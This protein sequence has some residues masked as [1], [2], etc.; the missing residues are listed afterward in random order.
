MQLPTNSANA[1]HMCT[2]ISLTAVKHAGSF[3]MHFRF[4]TFNVYS[5]YCTNHVWSSQPKLWHFFFEST[6]KAGGE[7]ARK[8]SCMFL[9]YGVHHYTPDHSLPLFLNLMKSKFITSSVWESSFPWK[10]ENRASFFKLHGPPPELMEK[11]WLPPPTSWGEYLSSRNS[12][13]ANSGLSRW[14]M[15]RCMQWVACFVGEAL[16]SFSLY[17]LITTTHI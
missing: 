5:Y 9:V 12:N 17:I 6:L 14:Q 3:Q 13:V 7:I 4:T 1:Q 10:M 16:P 2:A 11:L 8:Y 15:P